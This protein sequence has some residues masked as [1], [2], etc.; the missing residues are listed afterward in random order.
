MAL[1]Q[2]PCGQIIDLAL[3][4]TLQAEGA[5]DQA[6]LHCRLRPYWR[7]LNNCTIL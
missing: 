4:T 1:C 2:Q 7:F 6:D 3:A 5:F